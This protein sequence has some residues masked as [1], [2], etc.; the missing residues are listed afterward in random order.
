[1]KFLKQDMSRSGHEPFT[2]VNYNSK[3]E[4]YIPQMVTEA[5]IF[6]FSRF[7]FSFWFSTLSVSSWPRISTIL[8]GGPSVKIM[9]SGAVIVPIRK[10][11]DVT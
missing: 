1:M 4:L 10:Q 11:L 2:S 3:L 9:V 7:L 8:R 6:D 5:K